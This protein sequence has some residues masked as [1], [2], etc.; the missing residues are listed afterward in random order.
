MPASR[1]SA[2]GL[3]FF[4]LKLPA[5]PVQPPVDHTV[6]GCRCRC[7]E[8]KAAAAEAAHVSN[9][10][11]KDAYGD[12]NLRD[13]AVFLPNRT[14]N[15]SAQLLEQLHYDDACVD[16]AP[17]VVAMKH[18]GDKLQLFNDLDPN[19]DYQISADEKARME[20]HVEDLSNAQPGGLWS[21]MHNTL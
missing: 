19:G 14:C 2:R 21:I 12:S 3:H 13:A 7:S 6:I 5:A 11:T 10:R 15:F 17:G 20:Q 1:F 4:A 16:H 18:N 8:E 9:E